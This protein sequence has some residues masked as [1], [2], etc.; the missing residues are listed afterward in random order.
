MFRKTLAFVALAGISAAT[1]RMSDDTPTATAAP[2]DQAPTKESLLA[3][4]EALFE[5]G[6]E[7]IENALH[8]AIGAVETLWADAQDDDATL[9]ITTGEDVADAGEAQPDVAD[10]APTGDAG[11]SAAVTPADGSDAASASTGDAGNDASVT[12]ATGEN[13]PTTAA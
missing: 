3:R 9:D 11:E 1:F 8:D 12:N 6:I 10:T 13:A 5:R 4:V 7:G 2:V